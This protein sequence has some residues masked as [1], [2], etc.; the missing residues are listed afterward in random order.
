ML[1]DYRGSRRPLHRQSGST[2]LAEVRME[3]FDRAQGRPFGKAQGRTAQRLSPPPLTRLA[4]WVS[5]EA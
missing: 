4:R 1:I 3:P 2:E 5:T